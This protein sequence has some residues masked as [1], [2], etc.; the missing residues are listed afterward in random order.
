MKIGFTGTRKGLTA[1]QKEQLVCLLAMIDMDK[2]II[3]FHHGECAGADWDAHQI[4]RKHYP[5]VLIHVHP[6]TDETHVA[7][8]YADTR[9]NPKEYLERD[10]DIVNCTDI[11]I[12][13]PD[14]FKERRRSGT[15]YTARHA[16]K[17]MKDVV[18]LYP[19][20]EDAKRERKGE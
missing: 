5:L 12:A 14:G 9:S 18:Y 11:L 17:K 16:R 1:W 4:I 15:W 6:P 7:S 10:R 13:C 2:A 3:E 8:V 20:H 19:S